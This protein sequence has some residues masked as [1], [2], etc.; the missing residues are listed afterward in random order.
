M[1]RSVA[2][3][4]LLAAASPAFAQKCPEPLGWDAPERHVATRAPNFRFALK[5][6]SSHLL[7]LYP[8]LSVVLAVKPPKPA[9]RGDH[10]GLAALDIAKA[11]RLDVLLSER[12]YIDLVYRG[13]PLRSVEHGRLQCNGIFKRVS[14][15]VQPGRH[16]VQLTSSEAKAIRL[17]TI[18]KA[19][20]TRK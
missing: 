15:D 1:F 6:D 4:V 18:T 17:A 20:G 12:A 7:Q 2:A 13:K 8:Q 5:P 14:F 9:R 16:I 19:R 10:A 3:W 11:G